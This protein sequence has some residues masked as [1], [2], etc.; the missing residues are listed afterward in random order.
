[1][2]VRVKLL[3][4][5]VYSALVVPDFAILSKMGKKYV[6]VADASDRVKEV[7]VVIG[8]LQENGLRVIK[9]GQLTDK[10]RVIITRLL[11][12]QPKQEIRPIPR[13]AE[14]AAPPAIRPGLP[15]PTDK[16]RQGAK[17]K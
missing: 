2:F 3:I 11:D 9:G 6:Y 13:A 7:P 14:E 16:T 12:I 10:D 5:P 15:P 8:Q 1:M 4:G 17:G